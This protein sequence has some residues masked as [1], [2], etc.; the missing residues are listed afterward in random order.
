MSG[1]IIFIC[2]DMC[3]FSSL[4][5]AQ[6]FSLTN[7]TKTMAKRMHEQERDNRIVAKPKPTTM[8]LAFSVSTSSSTVNSPIASKSLGMLKSPCRTYWSSTGKLDARHRNHDA[9]WSSQGWQ[10]DGF[11]DVSTGKHVAIEE[12]QEHLN[13][14]EDSVSTWKFVAPGYPGT[15][16]N[17][18]TEG[19]DE[20]WPRCTW[21][22]FS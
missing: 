18:G 15:A 1:T 21:R 2:F 10:K 9:A 7:C 11:L 20:D 19:D 12:D 14:P 17:S 13:Y 6:N 3:H 16:G 5:C 22:T 4:C 8:N